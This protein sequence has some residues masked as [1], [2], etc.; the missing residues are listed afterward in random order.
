MKYFI[1]TESGNYADEFDLEKMQLVKAK[2][3]EEA[4]ERV[5]AD[6]LA[7]DE[8]EEWPK[9]FYFGTNEA[10]EYD[11]K[12]E[13]FEAISLQELTK[14]EYDTIEKYLGTSFGTGGIL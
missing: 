12:E 6:A 8:E 10:V 13:L 7:D 3:R 11:S 1:A 4:L 14:Q 5:F 2:S 9:E